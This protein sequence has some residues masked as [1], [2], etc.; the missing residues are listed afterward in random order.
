MAQEPPTGE[1]WVKGWLR[2]I[3]SGLVGL[4]VVFIAAFIVLLVAAALMLSIDNTERA[5]RLAEYAYYFLVVGVVLELVKTVL[6]G[7][8]SMEEGIEE[9][10]NAL[11]ETMREMESGKR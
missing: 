7:E 2:E 10:S 1:S 4:G 5:E 9:S 6:S 3:A 8:E 11:H